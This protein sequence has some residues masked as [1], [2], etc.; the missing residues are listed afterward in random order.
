MKNTKKKT[1]GLPNTHKIPLLIG[2]PIEE[3]N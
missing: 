1:A 2:E 3:K